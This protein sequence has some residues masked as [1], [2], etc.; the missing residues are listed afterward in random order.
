[1]E[2]RGELGKHECYHVHVWVSR[3]NIRWNDHGMFFLD[4]GL[5]FL[6]RVSFK[7]GSLVFWILDSKKRNFELYSYFI[8]LVYFV[9]IVVVSVVIIE[10]LNYF[11]FSFVKV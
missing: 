7:A 5:S 4:R 10:R 8:L 9:C 11:I 2:R 3:D 1:M 6:L